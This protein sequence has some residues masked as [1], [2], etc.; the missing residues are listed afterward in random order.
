LDGLLLTLQKSNK[1]QDYIGIATGLPAQIRSR[2]DTQRVDSCPAMFVKL[3]QTRG[4][5]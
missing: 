4:F 2:S 5:E 3:E 1:A